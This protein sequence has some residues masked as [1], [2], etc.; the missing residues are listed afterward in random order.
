MKC[1]LDAKQ[2][3]IAS[4]T[5]EKQALQV[6]CWQP[7]LRLLVFVHGNALDAACVAWL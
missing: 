6:W 2:S 4:V 3:T 7:N 1:E 5:Q